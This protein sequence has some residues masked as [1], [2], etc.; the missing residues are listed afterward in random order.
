MRTGGYGQARSELVHAAR[1]L[2]ATPGYANTSTRDIARRAGVSESLIFRRFGTKLNLFH[3]ATLEPFQEFVA[4]FMAEWLDQVESPLDNDTILRRF[5][6]SLYRELLAQKDT[7]LALLAADTFETDEPLGGS[8]PLL[9]G[10]MAQLESAVTKEAS[11]RGFRDLDWALAVRCTLGMIIGTVLLDR[12]LFPEGDEHPGE[13]RLVTMMSDLL[14]HG[15]E[16]R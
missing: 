6:T 7:V 5:T 14:L 9:S 2:F 11:A 3:E 15:F 4:N 13:V 12:W 1:E 16:A 8:E 10:Q